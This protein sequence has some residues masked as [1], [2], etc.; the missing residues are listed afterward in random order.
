MDFQIT[1]PGFFKFVPF[2]SPNKITNNFMT[3]NFMFLCNNTM[4]TLPIIVNQPF[5]M[6]D[7]LPQFPN[8]DFILFPVFSCG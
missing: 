6:K 7:L 3:L 1:I 2:S 4:H 5:N 8:C